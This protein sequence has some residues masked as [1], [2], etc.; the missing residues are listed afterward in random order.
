[1][2]DDDP[3]EFEVA[4]AIANLRSQLLAARAGGADAEI[5]LPIQ[6]MT[7][8]LEVVAVR[9]ADGKAGFRIPVVNVEIGGSASRQRQRTH[10]VTVVF[11]EPVDRA[12]NPVKVAQTTDKL[13]G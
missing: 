11:S 4:D 2:P 5:Q 6:S 9:S 1:M 7:L 12:G 3:H 8:V 10:T 13:K